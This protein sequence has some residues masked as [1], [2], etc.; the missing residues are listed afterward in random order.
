METANII[1]TTGVSLASSTIASLTAWFLAR[2]KYNKEV[3]AMHIQNKQSDLDFYEDLSDDNKKRLHDFI[4]EN[5]ELREENIRIR[6]ENAQIRVEN[7]AIR[8]ENAQ[9]LKEIKEVKAIVNK[10]LDNVCVRM[11]CQMRNTGYVPYTI[12]KSPAYREMAN[13]SQEVE[14]KENN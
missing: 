5:R 10:M 7:A 4:D 11:T 8:A 1:I 2:K 3:E 13:N 9:L 6:E 14:E 12:D